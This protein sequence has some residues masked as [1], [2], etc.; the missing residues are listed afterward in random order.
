M[1]ENSAQVI[2][3]EPVSEIKHSK[4][5]EDSNKKKKKLIAA[6][7]AI[8]IIIAAI[9]TSIVVMNTPSKD[10]DG[11]GVPDDE[12]AFPNDPNEWLDTD[13]DGTGNNADDDDDGDGVLDTQDDFPLDSEETTDTDGDGVGDAEDTDDDGD[14]TEDAV[15]TDDDGDGIPD[16]QDPDSGGTRS[17]SYSGAIIPASYI[18]E[19]TRSEGSYYFVGYL[20]NQTSG[21]MQTFE[22]ANVTGLSDISGGQFNI[23]LSGNSYSLDNVISND[24]EPVN[25]SQMGTI[26]SSLFK[27][28]EVSFT[29]VSLV[30]A[31]YTFGIGTTGVDDYIWVAPKRSYPTF[32]NDV[33]VK[34]TVFDETALLALANNFTSSIF[35]DINLGKITDLSK[36]FS[37]TFNGNSLKF[38]IVTEMTYNYP[39]S[40]TGD[41]ID[42]ITP[43][44]INSLI[45]G[46]NENFQTNGTDWIQSVVSEIGQ[47]VAIFTEADNRINQTKL[48]FLLY[49]LD[50]FPEF[51]GV[52]QIDVSKSDFS[53]L[54]TKIPTLDLTSFDFDINFTFEVNIGIVTGLI[55]EPY[56][57]ANVTGVW[58]IVEA[59]HTN[60]VVESI[61]VQGFATVLDAETVIESIRIAF[62][63]EIPEDTI[64]AI[65]TLTTFKNPAF[66]MML[67]EHYPDMLNED[68]TPA[69][70]YGA[71]AIIPDYEQVGS[72]LRY[73]DIK[74]VVY[75]PALYFNI[76]TDLSHLPLIIT[77][78]YSE[79]VEGIQEVT[80]KDLR[81]AN[82][83]LN[84][85]N[86]AYVDVDA[87][88]VGTTLKTLIKDIP[89]NDP[90]IGPFI[91]MMKAFPFDLCFYEGLK[92]NG[93]EE[94]Y[95]V[96]IIYI[97]TVLGPTYKDLNITNIRGMYIN[98][99]ADFMTFR[100]MVAENITN[101]PLPIISSE[102]ELI[103]IGVS[104]M[105]SYFASF[106][107]A[108]IS[109]PVTDFIRSLLNHSLMTSGYI[110]AFSIEEINNEPPFFNIVSPTEGASIFPSNLKIELNIVDDPDLVLYAE[111]NLTKYNVP[112]VGDIHINSIPI[113]ILQNANWDTDSVW[114]WSQLKNAA[115]SFG[116]FGDF[117]LL[118]N[119]EYMLEIRVHDFKGFS[120]TEY[121]NFTIIG[122]I[123]EVP[124]A[125]A[126]G[127]E[128]SGDI[129]ATPTIIYDYSNGPDSVEIYYSS[130]A[131]V[132]WTLWGTDLFLDGQWNI[133]GTEGTLPAAGTYYWNVRAIGTSNEDVPTGPG[134]IEAGPYVLLAPSAV[135][136]GPTSAGTSDECPTI[137]YSYTNAPDAVEIYYSINGGNTWILWGVDTVIEP[138]TG[139]WNV[140]KLESL[141]SAG[142]YH[143]NARALGVSNESIPTS[144]V[145]IEDGPYVILEPIATAT[146]PSIISNIDT[147]EISY[148]HSNSPDSVQIY[149]SD[150][151][152]SSWVLWGTDLIIDGSW[153]VL[154]TEGLLPADGTYEWYARAMG[155]SNE[156]I[157]TGVGDIE[158]GP[159]IM[160][161]VMPHATATAPSSSAVLTFEV[162]YSLSDSAPSSGISRVTLWYTTDGGAIWLEYGDDSDLTSPMSVTVGEGTYGWFFVAEDNA[163]NYEYDPLPAFV[164]A[165]EFSTT[166]DVPPTATATGPVSSASNIDYPEITYTYNY[167][168]TSVQVYYSDD[169]GNT[170][171]LWGTDSIV[172]G[173]WN[174]LGTESLP[175]SGTYYWN[176]RAIGTVSEAI[177]TGSGDI[178]A[179]SYFVDTVTPTATATGP[180]SSST[181][182]FSVSYSLNDPAPTSGI[183]EVTLWYT[184]DGGLTWNVGSIDADKTSP[185][186]VTVSSEGT[187][188]WFFVAE[189]NAGNAESA[190]IFILDSPEFST[191]VDLPPTASV[192]GP[193]STGSNDNTPMISYT[194]SNSPTSVQIYYSTNGGT[195][196]TLWGTDSIVDGQW[197]IF[198]TEGTLPASGTYRWSARAMGSTNEPVP[199]GAA[200]IEA[201][202]YLLDMV[203]PVATA[204]GP[205]NAVIG[206][207]P[208]T[209]SVTYS[210]SDSA[211]SSGYD[212]VALYYTITG[213]AIW[214]LYGLDSNTA[215]PMSVLV[216]PGFTYGWYFVATDNA[217]NSEDI[218]LSGDSPEDSTVVTV[219]SLPEY[220]KILVAPSHNPIG[221]SEPYLIDYCWNQYT[222]LKT[223]Q[224]LLKDKIQI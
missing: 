101:I 123:D 142:T 198:G 34:G 126:T 50:D 92:V 109:A 206:V 17:V 153:N 7:I 83:T 93:V 208:A 176:V 224:E 35:G 91:R 115:S 134:D 168:P 87:I 45:G 29:S 205:S 212:S 105:I 8:I 112:L 121:V 190:P 36:N 165:P 139:Q 20:S 59:T 65:K 14:G 215:S 95:Q 166:I 209:I 96:P 173:S 86:W 31:G 191:V 62:D 143:W 155:V 183:S 11:D 177:P 141:P 150:D 223:L 220:N 218:P 120:T 13:G 4:N 174:I 161:T 154:G 94:V 102:T 184:T 167:E 104:E 175:G 136:E 127:P 217:G 28:I 19:G 157:P 15:D 207:L 48:W 2:K 74:G 211:P 151:G 21:K 171:T 137:S 169:G 170:W 64:K 16:D 99:S 76:D 148:I 5:K 117:S 23:S 210:I 118:T 22:L 204:T 47:G 40:V 199:S 44:N 125:T 6:T 158:A 9:A 53:I 60:A 187:Y 75:D 193:S 78:S 216:N 180:A 72:G 214:T 138:I 10:T 152:G 133:F 192:T 3:E 24:T 196:W 128:D 66:V 160:D 69:W 1:E 221:Q 41:V 63:K 90:Y 77:D 73:L 129:S 37:F 107:P 55:P 89:V 30:Y 54:T 43:A 116:F 70:K 42:T 52:C 197:N 130:D 213:G 103:P 98:Y 178:E 108:N 38:V 172:D 80:V 39:V 186:S 195:S 145:D 88:T 135:A 200:S 146:G 149:Y 162:G 201:G 32:F 188:G 194:Y 27:N 163:G 67:D 164:N 82:V 147:P 124:K 181:L 25:V 222:R 68:G 61:D 144:L 84:E 113:P 182:T 114:W 219:F 111:A 57:K 12:D 119:G 18:D 159:Y 81:N 140:A 46:I 85:Y 79:V 58:G 51:P 202:S 131:G 26:I 122:G 97:A 33:T 110:L 100:D 179:G 49:P 156:P 185:I 132:T 56:V 189:D 203:D 71:I 106:L